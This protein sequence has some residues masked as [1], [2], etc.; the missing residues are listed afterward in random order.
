LKR[1]GGEADRGRPVEDT[2]FGE[3][4]LRSFRELAAPFRVV[5]REP[6]ALLCRHLRAAAW[7]VIHPV[8]E[9][10]DS[11]ELFCCL[12]TLRRSGPDGDGVE[13]DACTDERGCFEPAERS[14]DSES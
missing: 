11:A 14:R 5:A 8:L 1:I 3:D 12:K 9:S 10:L 2:F 7:S 6:E 4:P 13:P